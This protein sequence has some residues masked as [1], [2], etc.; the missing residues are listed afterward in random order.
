MFFRNQKP[1]EFTFE[2]RIANLKQLGFEGAPKSAGSAVV[3][4]GGY[5]ALLE[6]AGAGKVKIGKGGVLV[7]SEI[8]HL[9]DRFFQAAFV[10]V[11]QGVDDFH[12]G[13]ALGA[14]ALGA[15]PQ[16]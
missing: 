9:A 11:D 6:D 8:A 13:Q 5:G 14:A 16:A 7:G 4:R 12:G 2:E 1:H 3:K 15:L 10:Q